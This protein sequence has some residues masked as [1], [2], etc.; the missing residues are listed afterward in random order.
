MSLKTTLLWV[1]IILIFTFS[2]SP[3]TK[4]NKDSN[5][6][7]KGFV[8]PPA[9]ARP[10]VRWWWNG[11]RITSGEIKRELDIMHASGIGG[12]EINPIAFPEWSDEAG[13]VPVEW[14]SSEWNQLVVTAAREAK[15]KGM[16]TDLIV[17]SGWP[18]GGEFLT[19][20]EMIQRVIINKI[21]Y[22]GG[23]RIS[24]NTK[25]LV[26]KALKSQSRKET[27]QA[28]S[29]EV[30]FIRLVPS[31]PSG[32]DG[33][34]DLSDTFKR[35]GKLTM[36]VP[37]GNFQLVYG[38]RQRGHRDVVHGAPGAAGPVMD[39]YNKEATLA[40]LNRLK[41]ISEDTG[42]SL[43]ELLRALFCDS[44]ELAGANWT[45]G[46][47]DTFF[48][49]WNYRL[50]PF[51]PFIFYDSA[52]GY[53]KEELSPGFLEQI[54]RVRHDYN[55]LLVKIFLENFTQVFQDFCTENGLKCRYQAYGTPFLMGMLEANMIVDIPESNNW[56][57]SVDMGSEEW[58]WNQN[59]GYM[60]WNMYAASAG[61][62]RDRKIIS[63]EAMTNTRGVFKLSLE[64]IKRD[65]DM[66]F[67]TGINHTILHGFNYSPPEAGF[68]GWVRYGAYFNE[69]N[70]WWPYFPKWADYN[71]RLSY[72]LQNSKPVKNI[73]I[74]GP[75]GDIWSDNGLTRVPFH[76]KPWYCNRLWEPLSQAGSSCDYVNEE[77][78]KEAEKKEGS[79]IYGPMSYEAV[80]LA[81]VKSMEPATAK[82]LK[83]FVTV[84]GKVILI[85]SIPSLSLSYVD[86]EKNDAEVK[87]I[88]AELISDNP[89]NVFV[90]K[91]PASE[92][93]MLSWISD[94][95]DQTKIRKNVIIENPDK[96]V[97]QIN[98]R[99]GDKDIYFFTNSNR[100]KTI[101]LNAVFPTGKK[102]PWLWNPE[103][104]TRR[105][106]PYNS[107]RDELVI[108]LQPLESVLIVFDSEMSGKPQKNLSYT[109]ET[110][111]SEIIGPWK[112]NFAH[113][114][115]RIFERTFEKLTEFGLSDDSD[116]NGFAGV[117]RY[118][119][120]FS[121]D[122]IGKWL[123]LP[124]VNKG[125]T[126][127][128]LNNHLLGTN[129]YGR[130]LFL[131]D[132]NLLKG[133]NQLE[134]KYTTLLINYCR[135][136]KDNSVAQHWSGAYTNIPSGLEGDVHIL[137]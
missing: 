26:D 85:D 67:I 70:T 94:L 125:I 71:A 131:L 97:F 121:S 112:A 22:S 122:G 75:T 15:Q 130:P 42:I 84:G 48:K 118:K 51:Y 8:N 106:Y 119:T 76:I 30:F 136:L 23:D 61:H 41:K 29:N 137:N 34:I 50:E 44:I 90:V 37:K 5:D 17:G 83:D 35:Y 62:L 33:V 88:M 16:M 104:G 64:E 46:F 120:T 82:A 1:L 58:I 79:L 80:F 19:K 21:P 108:K 14:L 49:T 77:V 69:H 6:L 13:S 89:S 36:D 111:I 102:T 101:T 92:N 65:D 107:S 43:G 7:Y 53:G 73:A 10:F 25:S 96:N 132:G 72:T 103:S 12:V 59:H 68:P 128:Y 116:L 20:E 2:C 47:A 24:L 63:C 78:I 105:V 93:D 115:G 117:V 98:T 95:M 38:I 100:K 31:K 135:S 81:G 60:L 56:M 40:Y 18:F 32:I 127:V 4:T 52:L 45:D 86:A 87:A 74:L 110:V 9:E 123:E 28:R 134:I 109:D 54:R 91:A 39:H 124:E 11:N 126:E 57:Y 3:N 66:N 133:E 55:A 129:W 113:M 99:A 27:E 114:D